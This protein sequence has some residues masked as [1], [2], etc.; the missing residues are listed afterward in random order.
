M[1][2]TTVQVGAN[3]LS[4]HH[5]HRR[6]P[7]L[8]GLVVLAA[9]LQIAAGVGLAYVAGFSD[10]QDVLGRVSWPWIGAAV[11][12]I[13]VSF[14]AYYFAYRGIY[15]VEDGHELAR[16]QMV[17]VVTGGFGGFFAHG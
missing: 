7:E 6:G 9:V 8:A 5:L 17:S 10:V 15:A 11:G 13:V 14:L 2:A 3:W 12:G 1:R 4:G 16:R